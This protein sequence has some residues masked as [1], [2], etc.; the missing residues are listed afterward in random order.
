VHAVASRFALALG[1]SGAL[2]AAYGCGSSDDCGSGTVS[3]GGVCVAAGG[4]GASSTSSSMNAGGNSGGGGDNSGT[5][6]KFAGIAS[7][8]PASTT[9]VLLVWPPATDDKTPADSIRYAVYL[10]D[11]SGQEHFKS[12][13]AIVPKGGI[14]YLATGLDETKTYYAVVRAIDGD[15]NQDENTVEKKGA[16]AADTMPP[17]FGGAKAA[18]P[19]TGGEVEVSWAAAADDLSATD[20]ITYRVWVSDATPVD[21]TGAPAF[22]TTPGALTA[23]LPLPIPTTTYHF[24]VHAV[25]AAGNED[26]N[27]VE[28]SSKPGHDGNP[29]TFAGCTKA[30]AVDAGDVALAWDPGEDDT[31][32]V[33]QIAY[34]A[35]AF[36]SSSQSHDFS[37]AA[38]QQT[39]IGMNGGT[40]GGLKADTTY[41]F[42]CRAADLTGNEDQNKI[43]VHAKTPNDTSPPVFA[44]ITSAT[45]V[46]G[47]E[48]TQ[49]TLAWDEATDDQTAPA[50]IKY[51]VYQALTSGG[52]T[53]ATATK[54]VTGVTTAVVTVNP[55]TTYYWIV[56]ARDLAGNQNTLPRPE[57]EANGTSWVSFATNIQAA[58]AGSICTNCHS[59]AVVGGNHPFMDVNDAWDELRSYDPNVVKPRDHADSLLFINTNWDPIQNN[60]PA[61]PAGP[62]ANCNFKLKQNQIG[63]IADWIDQGGL[64]N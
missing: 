64:N 12:P 49:V 30:S 22:V 39:F 14:S 60:C 36:E 37:K 50:Q 54:T 7:I 29:P 57:L 58:I 25:D 11:A 56:R 6:P 16:P 52:E 42:V 1:V 26:A 21:T 55:A 27:K 40:V 34:T 28:V 48:T 35:Y 15:G 23:D 33:D 19:K 59:S 4:G 17:D 46:A 9:S 43:E 47:S 38:V 2:I 8:S 41:Y 18:T 31:T 45:L 62:P 53:F 63:W 3:K 51:D 24:V 32:P 10:A 61:M 20:A 44:G 5:P 13:D